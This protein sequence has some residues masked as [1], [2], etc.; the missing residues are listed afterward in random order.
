MPHTPRL[1]AVVVGQATFTRVRLDRGYMG[2]YGQT[3]YPA[4][5][6]CVACGRTVDGTDERPYITRD[7]WGGVP[8]RFHQACA[9]NGHAPCRLCGKLLPRL[10]CGCPRE[11]NANVCPA[12]TNADRVFPTHA[13]T[14]PHRSL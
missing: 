13:S 5:W 8:G 3:R 2:A 4:K 10:N 11:H 6:Q 1:R 9:D 7:M 12:K 14:T